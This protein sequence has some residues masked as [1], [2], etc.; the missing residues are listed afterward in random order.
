MQ[1]FFMNVQNNADKVSSWGFDFYP[2]VVW[3]GGGFGRQRFAPAA[4]VTLRHERHD[5]TCRGGE[6]KLMVNRHVDPSTRLPRAVFVSRETP[7]E[8]VRRDGA[9]LSLAINPPAKDAEP[10]GGELYETGLQDAPHAREWDFL[11]READRAL[12][13]AGVPRDAAVMDKLE[14]FAEYAMK[15]KHGPTYDS[16]HPVDVLLHSSYCTGA[17]NIFFAFANIEGIPARS[18][19]IA[20]HSMVEVWVDG[21]WHFVDNHAAGARLVPGADYVDVTI[22][23]DN[24]GNFGP[25]QLQYLKRPIAWGRSPWHYSSMLNWH[26]AWGESHK[27]GMRTDVLDGFG[28]SVPCD[29]CHA[30]ALYPERDTYPFP[31]WTGAPE[32]TLTEKASWIRAE[33]RL[34]PGGALLKTFYAGSSEDNPVTAARVDW[35]FKGEIGPSGAA[36]HLPGAGYT[37]NAPEVVPGRGGVN[38]LRF[39]LPPEVFA[40]PGHRTLVLE[41]RT[42]RHLRSVVYPTPLENPIYVSTEADP[43]VDPRTL[44]IEPSNISGD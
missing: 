3:L 28:I 6:L 41:N 5:D 4:E 33:L 14:A 2:A 7:G 35:W 12:E 17:A 23:P 43:D 30:G 10:V 18:I 21:R 22:E 27:R 24:F 38:K 13:E 19:S 9:Y 31:L 16:F 20:N 34:P 15:F 44:S 37:I 11:R 1:G 36:L 39:E 40:E 25:K 29:P 26:W 8:D 32:L 42:E